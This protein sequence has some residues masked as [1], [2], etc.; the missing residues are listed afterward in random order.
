[1]KL[2]LLMRLSNPFFL[3]SPGFSGTVEYKTTLVYVDAAGEE[4]SSDT[5]FSIF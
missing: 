4:I 3:K 5:V 1:M 2:L